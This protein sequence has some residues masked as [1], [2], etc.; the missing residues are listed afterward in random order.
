MGCSP[1]SLADRSGGRGVR[2]VTKER[3][4]QR[5]TPEDTHSD[6][7]CQ[8]STPGSQHIVENPLPF[9]AHQEALNAE[10]PPPSFSDDKSLLGLENQTLANE[11]LSEHKKIPARQP[12]SREQPLHP[13]PAALGKVQPHVCSRGSREDSARVSCRTTWEPAQPAA[14]QPCAL[15]LGELGT[16]NCRRQPPCPG[17]ATKITSDPVI[18]HH[19]VLVKK[20]KK[21]CL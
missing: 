1:E 4:H 9:P 21:I 6:S 2:E 18:L 14:L 8:T 20:T 19:A 5:G 11:A 16:Q 12:C 13:R 17:R 15:T 3:E 10:T 7:F